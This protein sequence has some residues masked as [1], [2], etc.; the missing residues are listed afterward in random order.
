[1]K[2]VL[3]F[4]ML[5]TWAGGLASG[6]KVVQADRLELRNEG[7]GEI[8]VLVG[9]PVKIER[10]TTRRNTPT[11]PDNSADEDNP[12]AVAPNLPASNASQEVTE[13]IEA[14]RVL[15]NRTERRLMLMGKVRYV[16]ADDQ[17]ITAD[18]LELFLEDETLEASA[19]RIET[20]DILLTGPV[21][22][23][24]AGQILLEQGYVTPCFGCGQEVPDYAFRAKEVVLYPGDRIIAREVQILV[25]EQPVLYLPVLLLNLAERRPR[26]D[27][28][29]SARDGVYF[30]ADLPYVGLG[31]VGFSLVRYFEKR[32]FGFGFDHI[33]L[34]VAKER[35]RLL[36]LPPT[37]P[38]GIQLWSYDFSYSLLQD[39]FQRDFSLRRASGTDLS[40]LRIEVTRRGQTEPNIRFTFDP[41]ID[42]NPDTPPPTRT[43]RVPEIELNVP[44]GLQGEFSLSGKLTVGGYFAQNNPF[45]RSAVALGP[46]LN[47][48][49]AL[50][51]YNAAY[52]PTL[53]SGGR[54]SLENRFRGFYY[55]TQER[56]IDWA[57][58]AT[59]SQ[60]VGAFTL[61]LS[62]NRDYKEGETPFN[63]DI[64]TPRPQRN[65]ATTASLEFKPTSQFNLVSRLPYDL[66][67]EEFRPL[68]TTLSFVPRPLNLSLSHSQDL[69]EG[70]R[71][72]SLNFT[73][74]P[75][76][77]SLR[78]TAGFNYRDN[79]QTGQQAGFTPLN[80]TLSYALTGGSLS[81]QHTQDLNQN[82]PRTTG[83]NLTLREGRNSITAQANYNHDQ[84]ALNSS[85]VSIWGLNNLNVSAN[86][87]FADNKT[88]QDTNQ[89][90][91][92]S[93]A[94]RATYSFAQT[95]SIAFEG[96]YRWNTSVLEGGRLTFNTRLAEPERLF[97]LNTVFHL[98]EP[99]DTRAY[100]SSARL[101][102]SLELLPAPTSLQDPVGVA[103]QGTLGYNQTRDGKETLSLDKFGPSFALFGLENTRVFLSITVS[104]N[105]GGG[106]PSVVK[107]RFDLVVDRCCW[108]FRL[109]LDA[110]KSEAK[111][112]FLYGGQAADFIFNQE[113]IGWPW[114]RRRQ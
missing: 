83:F 21:C 60:T 33:G 25:Q 64:V 14:E 81:L 72:T 28:G 77:F 66:L 45:N 92:D 31:G 39:G 68:E 110:A 90:L 10:N 114:D 59:I 94:L 26:F 69:Q 75:N 23:R 113:G 17:T 22:S 106:L 15:Y 4:L 38:T 88:D 20:G 91:E 48:G 99:T 52:S 93:V 19:V 2:R 85:V 109:T 47:A 27:L 49:R 87:V 1:M 6:F 55:T 53:W 78:A 32:G 104:Q 103:L 11:A 80:L 111:F 13:L 3:L 29:Q 56:Q 76:P 84:S 43:Q 67:A 63:F 96:R 54:F 108:A 112:G 36:Y 58:N 65:F 86:A 41:Y 5:L 61:T 42:H 8:I 12:R 98:P 9:S 30:S 74:S 34:G 73:Y 24:Y 107:P 18:Q 70:P 16:T 82:Q 102:S 57:T 46:Y 40:D 79:P 44:R 62:A 51:E 50:V 95:T 89:A 35:Y 97:D 7:D 105:F 100:F 71:S 101:R 37:T